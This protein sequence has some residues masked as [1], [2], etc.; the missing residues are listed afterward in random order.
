MFNDDVI[1]F[2]TE[3]NRLFNYDEMHCA[4]ALERKTNTTYVWDKVTTNPATLEDMRK[5]FRDWIDRDAIFVCHNLIGFD[6]DVLLKFLGLSIP[7]HNVRDT[8][9]TSRLI[10]QG[11]KGGH[12]LEAWGERLG[13]KKKYAELTDFETYDPS[14]LERCR[15]DVDINEGVYKRFERFYKDPEWADSIELEHFSQYISKEL[16]DNGFDVDKEA[17]ETMRGELTE[18]IETIDE[19]LALDF[20]PKAVP[21]RVVTPRL[22]KHGTFNMNDF[23][24]RDDK[25]L[26]SFT[27]GPFTLFEYREFNPGSIPQII[28]RMN[29]AG[30]KP[31]AKTKSHEE[32]VRSRDKERIEKFK[33]TGWKVN[34]ENLSTLPKDAPQSAHNL[35]QRLILSSRLSSVNELTGLIRDDGKIH[36]RFNHIGAWTHRMSHSNPNMANIPVGGHVAD[37]MTDFEKYI[38]DLNNRMRGAFIAPTG[39]KLIGTDADGIQ[40]RIFAHYVNDDRLLQSLV[41]GTKEDGTDIHTLHQG[42]LGPV[43]KTRDMAKTFIYAFL[44]GAGTARVAD[45]LQTSN[46]NAKEA[47]ENFLTAYPGLTHLRKNVIPRDAD[48]GYFVSLDGRKVMCDSEHLMLAGYLQAGEKIIMTRSLKLW[49]EELTERKIPYK[50]VNFVHDE[51]QTVVPDDDEIIEIVSDAQTRSFIQAGLDLNLNCPLAGNAVVGQ[52]WKETH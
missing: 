39:S 31:T 45:I 36:G 47:V 29:E 16:H 19:G 21:L 26:S 43:C 18:R 5:Q 38:T 4:V 48:R 12:S 17:F 2:D 40:M 42:F 14:M 30:W 22:T 28:E 25:D 7:K 34:E 20:P 23:R 3:T 49:T 11:V 44:L 10:N 32:A 15:S 6:Y 52:T 51:W 50:L 27:G 37:W 33:V 13:I 46:K 35:A 9:V 24:W 1:V 8:L 41:T